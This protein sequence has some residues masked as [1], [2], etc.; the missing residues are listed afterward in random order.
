MADTKVL[1]DRLDEQLRE[2]REKLRAIEIVEAMSTELGVNGAVAPRSPS[3]E[4]RASGRS[5]MEM[6]KVIALADHTKQW[7]VSTMTPEVQRAGRVDA[8][9]PNVTT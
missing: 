8:S 1:R 5:I 7:N 4:V 6:C 9:K 3:A 2:I